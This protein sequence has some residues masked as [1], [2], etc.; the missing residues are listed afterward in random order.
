MNEEMLAKIREIISEICDI[1]GEEIQYES[2]IMD[3][4]DL[5]SIEVISILSEIQ[6]TYK[7]NIS[8]NEMMEIETVGD[9]IELLDK[10]TK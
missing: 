6:R 3:D 7:V 4:L 5:A 2:S 1:D 8:A 10:K 9:F